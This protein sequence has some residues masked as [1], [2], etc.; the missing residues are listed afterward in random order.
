MLEQGNKLHRNSGRPYP[1]S[2]PTILDQLRRLKMENSISDQRKVNTRQ[3]A[4]EM[5]ESS[6]F[7]NERWE[8]ALRL[9]G[10]RSGCG[11][12]NDKG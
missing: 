11:K 10:V 12:V 8:T 7:K 1:L 4:I 2:Q 6:D 5:M 9:L 3:S